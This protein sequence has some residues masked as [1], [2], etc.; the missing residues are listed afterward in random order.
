M[1]GGF[2]DYYNNR[3]DDWAEEIE[4]IIKKNKKP[5]PYEELE[6]YEK[7]SWSYDNNDTDCTQ[8]NYDKNPNFY[9]EYSD[10]TIENYKL[11][12]CF[13]KLASV[14]LHRIDWLESGDDSEDSFNERLKE[15]LAKL[16][17]PKEL[18]NFIRNEYEGK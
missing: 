5:I 3:L 14:Y 15:D 1:S 11:A 6:N 16:G 4:Q 9:Y 8:K 12:L 7:M 13:T 17:I 18:Y 2:F 10:E